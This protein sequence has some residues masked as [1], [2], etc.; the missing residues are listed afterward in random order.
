MRKLPM[1]AP[2]VVV[3]W[4][5][6]A[7]IGFLGID[8]V[9]AHAA[10][11]FAVPAEWVPVL[12][13]A[14][15]TPLLAIGAA[16][17]RLRTRLRPLTIA[18]GCAAIAVGV[19]GM[20]FH[21][22]SAFFEDQT[23]H[24]LVYSAPFVAPLAYVG[25]GLLILLSH[26]ERPGSLE[27]ATWVVLL[28]LGGL[29][30]NLVLSLL[31]HAQNGFFQPVEWSAVIASAFAVSF[32]GMAVLRPEPMLIRA[33]LLVLGVQSLIGVLGFALHVH[34]DLARPG[35][36]L[37]EKA[38]YGAPVFAPLLFVNLAILAALGLEALRRA[39]AAAAT[40]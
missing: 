20:L 1:P 15:A 38:I 30:G 3:E 21:L 7:N 29:F 11:A 27:W 39:R 31:D 25:V 8:I 22:K 16:G 13:S 18:I 9:F 37:F 24:S 12:F 6:V 33:S 4:F 23:L 28:A 14:V 17:E 40:A 32:V 36:T 10:N 5:A 34:A 2:E 35:K 19:A 26:V